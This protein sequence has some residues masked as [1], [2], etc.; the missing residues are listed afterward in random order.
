[1]NLL[2]R[3]AATA[4]TSLSSCNV[5]CGAVTSERF[6]QNNITVTKITSFG[7]ELRS[8]HNGGGLF[9]GAK[10]TM[11]VNASGGQEPGKSHGWVKL[12]DSPLLFIEMSQTGLDF[13]WD[14]VFRGISIGN[15]YRACAR[16]PFLTS[17]ILVVDT[18]KEDIS[19]R[20]HYQSMP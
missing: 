18:S 2:L 3:L 16:I 15:E 4:M 17:S 20:F 11:L 7:P 9:L 13:S 19:E 1:M 10:S 8:I 5:F 6:S 12:P 14:E